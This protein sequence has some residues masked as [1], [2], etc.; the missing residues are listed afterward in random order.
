MAYLHCHTKGCNWSQDDFYSKS[1]NPLTKIWSNIKWLWKPRMIEWDAG[2]ACC[3]IP[4]LIKFT[5]INVKLKERLISTDANNIKPT[6]SKENILKF[7]TRYCCFSWSWLLLEIVKDIKV[8]KETKWWTYTS[9]KKDKD[10]E[11]AKCPI[12]GLVNFDID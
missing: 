2:F 8:A 5:G 11:K 12:C 1:Y 4:K 10:S 3:D 7:R 9:W 6:D